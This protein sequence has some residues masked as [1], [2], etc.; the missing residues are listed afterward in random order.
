MKKIS[1]IAAFIGLLALS[2]CAT[3]GDV[4][5]LQAQVDSLTATV[6]TTQDTADAA[7]TASKGAQDAAN[8]ANAKIDSLT[9]KMTRFFTI[10]VKK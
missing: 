6:K 7:L 4:A 5:G 3:K 2:G 1:V 9:E 8:T 10:Q